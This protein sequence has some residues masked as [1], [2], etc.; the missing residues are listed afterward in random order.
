MPVTSLTPVDPKPTAVLEPHQEVCKQFILQHPK[1]GV[2]LDIGYGKTLTTLDS[3]YE[4]KPRNV[5][6]VAPKAIARTTWHSEVKK[7]S[8]PFDCFSMVEVMGKRGK[9]KEIPMKDLI[10]LYEAIPYMPKGTTNL[11]ITSVDRIK[12]LAGW[13]SEHN[14][15]PFDMIVC[16]EFQA[17]KN[18]R[19]ER[20]KAIT[21]LANHTRRLVGLTGS[22]MPNSLEDIW[23]EIK[24]LDGGQRLGR[25]IT[26]FRDKYEQSTMVVKG[27]SVGWKPLPGAEEEIFRKIA[28]IAIS[29]KTKIKLPPLVI[30]D[31]PITLSDDEYAIYKDFLKDQ[32]LD[33]EK[34]DPFIGYKTDKTTVAPANAAVM[35]AKLLQIASGSIYDENHEPHFI[36]NQKIA[37]TQYI[38]DNTGGPV[39]V[40]YNYKC[41]KNRLMQELHTD[42]G[43]I[44]S[45]DGSE[46]MKDEWNAG[47]YPIML[48]QP[49][50]TCHGINL[51]EG[52]STLIWYSLPWNLEHYIQ[53]NGRVYRKGQTRPV[54]IHRLIA[55]KTFDV[56]VAMALARKKMSNE[57]LIDAVRRE[58]TGP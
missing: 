11:F 52:G 4:L 46:R 28:D 27:H 53:T 54:M 55:Q 7:F 17:F 38:I 12:H 49:A 37:A 48:F 8:Y 25:F 40:A 51:Q 15:W 20:T 6:V 2:F 24:I 44:V 10:P 39:I 30:H 19:S 3:I 16:D 21:T 35:A 22:P 26:H 45:F 1:C 5:L 33:L 23:S 42:K 57:D 18:G 41:D 43:P 34:L 32:V 14:S 36:H 29:V 56:R 58:V 9:M 50:A 31:M 13:C 47:M